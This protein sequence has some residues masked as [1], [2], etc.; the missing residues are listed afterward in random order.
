LVKQTSCNNKGPGLAKLRKIIYLIMLVSPV[1]AIGDVTYVVNGLD[2]TLTAN[3]LSHV[4]TVQLG[5]RARI[6]PRDYEKVIE[7][8]IADARA[9]L[10]PFGYYTPDISARIIPQDGDNTT[11]ELTIDAGR[12]VRISSAHV[13]VTGHGSDHRRFRSWL[14]AWPLTEGSVLNQVTWESAKQD[15]LDIA[16]DRGYLS[17][18]FS[19]HVLEID[20]EK[21]TADLRLVLNTGPRYVMGDVD[22]GS[23]EL[24]P[25]ILEHIP[26]FEKGDAYTAELV[27]RL[28]TDL[29]K[30]GYFDDIAVVETERHELDPPAVDFDV[31]VETET[32]NHYNGAIGWGDD[33]GFRLQANYSRHPMSAYGDRLDI[34][35]GYQELDNQVTV[36]GRYRK[37]L[38]NRARQWWDAEVTLQFESIDL[39]VRR[40]EE[41]EDTIKIARGD[42][43]EQHF[44]FGRLRLR[45]FKGGE[46]QLFTTPF[47]QYLDNSREFNELVPVIDPLIINDDPDF[48]EWLRGSDRALS[49]GYDLEVVD[50]QG[51]RFETVGR[52]DRAWVFHSNEAF[53]STV[54][55][56]QLYLSTRRSYLRGDNLKFHVRAE[57]GYTD[58]EVV[59]F[60][61]DTAEGPIAVEQTRLPNYYRFKAGGSMSVRGYGFEQLSNNDVG[62]NHIITGS[63]EVE[64]RFLESWSGAAFFDFGNA[65][66]DWNNRELKRGVGVGIRWY[67]IAGEIRVDIAQAIDFKDKPWQWHITIGTP[68]L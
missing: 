30:T 33:T 31:Q 20:L 35:I 21:N 58:A 43:D 3:V 14:N 16:N 38:R 68:L 67:S 7:E 66:N 4:D 55:F 46:A 44:R 18:E 53:G 50:V 47:V 52:R 9:A 8:A 65:F 15:A 24:K 45:N 10:R 27:R 34:G 11:L 12:P 56:T 6:R 41:T 42:L 23:H 57:L 22:F 17:A 60:S 39:E 1:A 48:Q 51:R 59:N 62:S 32:K 40:D 13:R 26:R 54:D 28:R 64:Y 36:R 2:E 19:E 61:I 63:A 49:I 5:A 25:D 37:P 29:W